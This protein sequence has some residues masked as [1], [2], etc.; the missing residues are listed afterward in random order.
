MNR[1]ELISEVKKLNVKTVK[2]AHM[3]KT[4]DLQTL[5]D[6]YIKGAKVKENT[7]TSRV[8]ELSKDQKTSKEIKS[9]LEEEGWGSRMKSGKVRLNY[10]GLILKNK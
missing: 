10:I 4:E 3:M 1:T 8:L 2:P 6:K 7:M 9:I 5:V